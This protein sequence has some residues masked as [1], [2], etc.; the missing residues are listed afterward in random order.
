MKIEFAN[1]IDETDIKQLLAQS[2]LPHEDITPAHLSHF[3]VARENDQLIGVIG[4]EWLKEVALVRSLAV[5]TNHRRQGIAGQLVDRIEAQAINQVTALYLLT[6][7]AENYFARRGYEIADRAT[8][9][10]TLQTT[11]EFQSIC[12]A[13]AIC[14]KKI[15]TS[16][17]VES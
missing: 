11:A 14:M 17:N 15:M 1:T 9:P 5:S 10:A 13:T 4:V 7:T 16:E 6:T 8:A 2:D 3:L 12:P